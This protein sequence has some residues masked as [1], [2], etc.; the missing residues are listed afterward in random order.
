M[1]WTVWL[2]G[3]LAALS[4]YVTTRLGIVGPMLGALII[5]MIL[6]YATGVGASAYEKYSHPDN[7]DAGLS[8][9]R[10]LRG[11][12]KKLGYVVVIAVALI[13]DWIIS[14][15]LTDFG[16]AANIQA[17]FGMLT[18]CWLILNEMLSILENAV[19]ME[20]NLPSFLVK[21]VTFLKSKVD[22]KG[23]EKIEATALVQRT[24][25]K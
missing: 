17:Y 3:A 18:T 19:R 22:V 13:L 8:S 4:A 23:E 10:G 14:K 6:D 24:S 7:P 9:K 15:V 11:I 12:I 16:I 25:D 21:A 1:N 20:V 5:L 2:K